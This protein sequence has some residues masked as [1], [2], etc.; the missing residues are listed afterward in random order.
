MAIVDEDIERVKAAADFVQIAGEQMALKKSGKR[1]V[2]L[3]PFHAEK[4]PSFSI[5]AEE[6]LY[7]CYGCQVGG[8]II[9][10]VER[11]QHLDFAGAV[12][13]LAGRYNVTLN[14][15]DANVGRE[16]TRR[17]ELHAAMQRAVDFYHERLLSAADAGH[18]RGYLR[19][20]GYD[21]DIVERFRIGWAP[22]D[23][24]AL[25]KSLQLPADVLT[26]TG[27][28]FVN[29][30]GRAQDTFRARLMFPI[31]D[32]AGRPVAFGGRVMPGAEGSK[33]KNSPETKLY[34]KSR[35]L[36]ALNWAKAEA[37]RVDEIIVCEGYTDVIAF[38]QA[39]M[40]RA[41][42]TCGT[43]LADE[44][45]RLLKGFAP[46]IVL[47]YDADAAG[48][49]A[50]ARFYEWEQRYDVDVAVAEMPAGSDPADLAR[51]D[52][53]AL[54]QA[55]KNA[56]RFL[57]FRL[58]RVLAAANLRSPEGRAKAAE[59]AVAVV[60]EHPNEHVRDQYLG[61]V[62]DVTRVDR[63]RL[64]ELAA[65]GA[66]RVQPEQWR[67]LVAPSSARSSGP[68]IEALRLAVHR[69]AEVAA[70]LEGV[71][72]AD[73]VHLDAFEAL[74]RAST[75]GDAIAIARP[76]AAALIQRLAVEEAPDVESDDV[77]RRLVHAAGMRALAEL[78]AESRAK[79]A[80]VE[81]ARAM[82]WLKLTT[83]RLLDA[84][85]GTDAA[86]QLVAWLVQLR[87]E[88]E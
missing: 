15:D 35:V 9:D 37:A 49:A 79:D 56:K 29:R 47:A 85:A 48:Q 12:E 26:D 53:D 72:F 40:P 60:A 65:K 14:Y 38:F 77:V 34:S 62:A 41:V 22:D 32:A 69:P 2:G 11:T 24:D 44:H 80:P 73:D 1:W 67:K 64:R 52:P 68:E 27:L 7:Y 33:Y 6:K 76:E 16:R 46:R 8:D 10:F 88:G 42:A 54:R 70:R 3:C 43:A 25:A 31:F 30:V 21:R 36:Y 81:I 84:S 71:L 61:R 55:V 50:A 23:W 18:A 57:E 39:D 75:L 59:A 87:S 28:G 86:E 4:T 58:D 74:C 66:R 45:F 20:R 19:T 63:D 13:I 82:E 78:R 17:T 83:E 5:N 51:K